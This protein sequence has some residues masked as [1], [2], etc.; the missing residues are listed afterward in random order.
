MRFIKPNKWQCVHREVWAFFFYY[1]DWTE[2]RM[3]R[4]LNVIAGISIDMKC[5]GTAAILNRRTLITAA[6]YLD[7]WFNRQRD[8][9][10]WALG[11]KGQENTPY[12]Y[13]VWRLTRLFPKSLNPEHWHGPRGHC[14]ILA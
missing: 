10:I 4:R 12:R 8:L 5:L 3:R 2:I 7:P 13:R 6:N 9:R 11:R 1:W 14:S